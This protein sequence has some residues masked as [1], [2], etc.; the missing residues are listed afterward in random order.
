MSGFVFR[1]SGFEFPES[2]FGL[3]ETGLGIRGSGFGVRGSGLGYQPDEA[4]ER[5]DRREDLG[6]HGRLVRL[7]D[8]V[9]VIYQYRHAY[10]SIYVIINSPSARI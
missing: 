8:P 1:V 4:G 3:Q 5:L 10:I 7:R 9:V 2:D 6:D